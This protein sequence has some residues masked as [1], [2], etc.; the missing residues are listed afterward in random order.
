MLTTLTGNIRCHSGLSICWWPVTHTKIQT[1]KV[2][3]VPLQTGQLAKD[4]LQFSG[5]LLKCLLLLFFLAASVRFAE[6]R[7]TSCFIYNQTPGNLNTCQDLYSIKS[8]AIIPFNIC[9]LIKYLWIAVFFTLYSYRKMMELEFRAHGPKAHPFGDF[10][11]RSLSL[12]LFHVPL[13]RA[14]R[15][16]GRVWPWG[17]DPAPRRPLITFKRFVLDLSYAPKYNIKYI[18][19]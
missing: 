1:Y 5:D 4:S 9:W 3:A 17:P 19:F 2:K 10:F 7:C 12:S 8:K 6:L 15:T 11:V 18:Y 14:A 16:M 13:L